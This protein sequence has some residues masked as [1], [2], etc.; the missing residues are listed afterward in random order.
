M[1]SS[2]PFFARAVLLRQVAYGEADRIVTLYTR[3]HGKVSAAA[4]AAARSRKRFGG[5][6]LFVIGDA[7]LRERRGQDLLALEAFEARRDFGAI[8]TDVV[9][10]AHASYATELVRELT[11]P[12]QPDPALF[13]L[14]EELYACVAAAPPAADTLRAF[15]LRLMDELGLRPVLDRCTACDAEAPTALDAGGA[16]VDP[17]RGGLLCPR[18]APRAAG[19]GVRPL[20]AASR[21]RLLEAQAAD[22]LAEAAALPSLDAEAATR[23]REAMHALVA[24][25]LRQPLR[26]L[27]FLHQLRQ[28]RGA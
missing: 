6:A 18:C 15:E 20:P 10:L 21:R 2:T 8:A 23:A 19:A 26:S 25:H 3:E 5:M 13:D 7:T 16:V 27:E 11:V 24:A 12:R 14:V 1:S 4:K 17:A 22:S 28:A 9:R